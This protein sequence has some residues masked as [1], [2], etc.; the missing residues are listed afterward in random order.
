MN[1]AK[2][3]TVPSEP[4][5]RHLAAGCDVRRRL[6]LL[7][8]VKGLAM[9]LTVNCPSSRNHGAE[10]VTVEKFHEAVFSGGLWAAFLTDGRPVNLFGHEIAVSA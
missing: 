3:W 5:P 8:P 10:I 6:P 7:L 4:R 1:S 9:K 2:S